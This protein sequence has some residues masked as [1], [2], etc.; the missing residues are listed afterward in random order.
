MKIVGKPF[1]FCLHIVF[2][3]ICSQIS[4]DSGIYY[5]LSKR[6]AGVRYIHMGKV[7]YKKPR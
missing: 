6:A 1:T 7:F 4:H 3:V 2:K 5:Q